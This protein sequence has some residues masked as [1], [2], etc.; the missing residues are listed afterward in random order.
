MLGFSLYSE[1]SGSMKYKSMLNITFKN[2]PNFYNNRKKPIND[3]SKPQEFQNDRAITFKVKPSFGMVSGLKQHIPQGIELK[4]ISNV[5]R[6]LGVEEL[7]IG[8]NVQL[9]RLLKSAMLRVKKLGFEVPT[10][11]RC[12][13]AIFEQIFGEFDYKHSPGRIKL[14][15]DGR[16]PIMFFNPDY[17]WGSPYFQTKTVDPRHPIWH[18]IGHYLHMKN[19]NNDSSLLRL[20]CDIILDSHQRE[21]I[22]ETMGEHAICRMKGMVPESIA[23]IFARFMSGESCQT[24]PPEIFNI[25]STYNGPMPKENSLFSKLINEQLS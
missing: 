3:F 19:Y 12:E 4:Q 5:L 20:L 24:L 7:E 6:N 22:K 23:E 21:V 16:D 14:C 1:R 25:Y 13:T 8:E 11:I 17:S 2:Q 15:N 10:R 9:A 18:E